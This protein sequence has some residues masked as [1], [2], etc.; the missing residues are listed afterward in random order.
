MKICLHEYVKGAPFYEQKELQRSEKPSI[1][2]FVN[3]A[4]EL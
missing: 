1:E 2:D 4:G 3:G